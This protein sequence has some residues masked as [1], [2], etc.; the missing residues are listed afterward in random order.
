MHP[1]GFSFFMKE[2]N[3]DMATI[4]Y[5]MAKNG[6]RDP[7][8][9]VPKNV[10]KTAGHTVMTASNGEKGELAHGAD[11]G[12]AEI[13]IAIRDAHAGDYDAV[14]FA[15]GPGALENLDNEASYRLA[16]ETV[17]KE[18]VL[19][20]I[21]IAPVVLARAGVL[22]GKKAVVWSSADDTTGIDAI[23]EEGAEYIDE[24]VVKDG[25]VITARNPRAAQ[26]FGEALSAY[27]M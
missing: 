21:C 22:E 3:G 18:K 4:L 19:G 17:Y 25:A 20:A 2:Y 9:F 15:G 23:T 12:A 1:W 8:Y 27:F 24:P 6:F 7:E 16:Q 13:D 14:V 5:V 26:E 11:G 10:L